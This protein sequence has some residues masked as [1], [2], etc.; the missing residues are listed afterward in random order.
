M[1]RAYTTPWLILIGAYEVDVTVPLRMQIRSTRRDPPGMQG[2]PWVLS[3]PLSRL[4]ALP[5]G[6]PPGLEPVGLSGF[7]SHRPEVSAS[8]FPFPVG[9]ERR[10]HGFLGPSSEWSWVSPQRPS[11]SQEGCGQR[12]GRC[13]RPDATLR[14]TRRRRI[15]PASCT[16]CF[17]ADGNRAALGSRLEK[18]SPCVFFGGFA[19]L[20]VLRRAK[21]KNGLGGSSVGFVFLKWL[22]LGRCSQVFKA[23]LEKSP[24]GIWEF[25]PGW[26]NG[27]RSKSMVPCWGRCTTHFSLF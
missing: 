11:Q 9:L 3:T 10:S 17:R 27:H 7:W 4:E 15:F 25:P 19:H 2:L 16:R 14:Q 18:G 8:G 13:G 6:L 20:K 12:C 22:A 23:P 21:C 5:L 26:A 1:N 24:D